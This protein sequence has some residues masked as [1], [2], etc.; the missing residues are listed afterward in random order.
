MISMI[1]SLVISG[2]I[3]P[4]ITIPVLNNFNT[5]MIEYIDMMC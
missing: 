2:N 1:S 3:F 5:M 4:Q